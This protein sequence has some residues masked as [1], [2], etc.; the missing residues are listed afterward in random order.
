MNIE[1]FHYLDIARKVVEHLP[2]GE[3]Y[4]CFQTPAFRVKRKLLARIQEE[5]ETLAVH[6]NER[7]VWM[8]ANPSVFFIT[9][10]Y[11]TYPFCFSEPACCKG[12]GTT[13]IVA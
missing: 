11:R 3:E 12:S 10:H 8:K 7:N 9:D 13:T 6:T 5:G 1:V 2:G 4:T